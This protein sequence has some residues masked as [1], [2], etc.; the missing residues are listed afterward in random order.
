MESLS[1]HIGDHYGKNDPS[2]PAR[3]W[4]FCCLFSFSDSLHEQADDGPDDDGRAAE[5]EHAE[6]AAERLCFYDDGADIAEDSESDER[7][8]DGNDERVISRKAEIRQERYESSDDER[9][10][11]DEAADCRRHARRRDPS[12][13][14]LE[15]LDRF[16]GQETSDGHGE[17]LDEYVD[18][19]GEKDRRAR[20]VAKGDA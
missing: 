18:D 19:A 9:D 17:R 1:S 5:D 14:V 2:S 20:D 13:L 10:E 6:S 11:H 8:D 4:A 12:R 3:G 15:L 16:L 7:D